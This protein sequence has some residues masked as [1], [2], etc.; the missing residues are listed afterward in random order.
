[1]PAPSTWILTEG[2][3]GTEAPCR[4]LARALGVT[5][6]VKRVRIR[7]PWDWLPGRLWI[8]PLAAPAPGSDALEPPW[9]ELLISSGNAAAPLALAIKRASR[10]ATRIVHVQT[11]RV[12]L[13]RFDLVVAPQHD[14]TSGANVIATR[15]A[16]HGLDAASLAVAAAEWAR[17]LG[18]LPRPRL[19][20]LCGGP[21]G[22]FELG[23]RRI[24][25]IAA[26]LRLRMHRDGIG[27]MVS[28]S[29]R[30]GAANAAVLQAE[31]APAG[32]FV[33]DGQAP[34]PYLGMLALAD[35]IAVTQDSVTMLSE[36]L[37]TGKPVYWIPL[38]GHSRR[39]QRFVDMLTGQGV[40][41]RFPADDAPLEPW[42]YAP[43]DDTA[44]VAAEI[45]RR[46]GWQAT[47]AAE[48][49]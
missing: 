27:V 36:A 49:K 16:L 14:R 41:R 1:M 7:R 21:N 8:R 42:S 25:E 45:R 22:R 12:G 5:P 10:G 13:A 35:A 11:P 34:N 4:G 28:A 2:L 18:A 38:A 26:S 46:F 30:T 19:A 32:A 9:P 17:T 33:W 23:P 6:V 40:L 15:A 48:T 43:P 44:R 39:L 3:A 20:L 31:L 29:R 24:A 37:A 47:A